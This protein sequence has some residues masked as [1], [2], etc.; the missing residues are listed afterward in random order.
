MVN[1]TEKVEQLTNQSSMLDSKD[2]SITA[3]IL[4]QVVKVNGTTAEVGIT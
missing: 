4:E 2:I 3:D 1:V